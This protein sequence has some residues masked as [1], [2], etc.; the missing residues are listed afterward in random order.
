MALLQQLHTFGA[1]VFSALLL[2]L[3]LAGTLA[4]APPKPSD[5]RESE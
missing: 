1:M 2:L 5:L 4:Q 3:L